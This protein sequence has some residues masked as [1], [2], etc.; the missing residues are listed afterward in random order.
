MR[1]PSKETLA[2][3]RSRY[4]KGAR[5]ELVRM[6]DPQAPPVGT[7]GTVLGVDDVGSILVAWD[8]GSGLNVAF[9]EDVCRKV[10][11]I[12][13]CKMHSFQTTRSCSLWLR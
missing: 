4:P 10:E 7:K 3:L 6:D 11:G 5:V 2:L 12:R 1:L 9:G 8:N 13:R